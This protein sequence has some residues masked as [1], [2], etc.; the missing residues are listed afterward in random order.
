MNK[1]IEK[2]FSY[3]P[4]TRKLIIFSID[5]ILILFSLKISFSS[6]INTNIGFYNQIIFCF[7][8]IVINLLFNH[9]AGNYK[10]LTRYINSAYFYRNFI[11]TFSSILIVYILNFLI[12]NNSILFREWFLLFFFILAL[13]TITRVILRDTIFKLQKINEKNRSNVVI[14]G[15]GDAGVALY[16]NLTHS[17]KFNVLGFVDDSLHK[18]GRTINN[19][20]IYSRK[21]IKKILK[22]LI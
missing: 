19:I 21:F 3:P 2:V 18:A 9:L 5:L 11:T 15:A 13:T 17:K 4:K 16:E 14:F 7:L 6:N 1:F 8:V 22:Q 20:P 10:S 12:F